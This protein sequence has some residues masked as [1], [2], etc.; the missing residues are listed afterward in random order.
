MG[1][2]SFYSTDVMRHLLQVPNLGIPVS[3]VTRLRLADRSLIPGTGNEDSFLSSP[4]RPRPAVGPTQNPIQWVPGAVSLGAMR[5]GREV[6]HSPPY[7]AEVK[8]P[9]AIPPFTHNP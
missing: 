3:T 1:L 9:G 2:R 7:N 5:T 4:P 6:D 8:M